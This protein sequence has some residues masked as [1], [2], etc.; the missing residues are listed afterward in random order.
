MVITDV[1]S[2]FH[3]CFNF[4]VNNHTPENACVLAKGIPFGGRSRCFPDPVALTQP[5]AAWGSL[6]TRELLLEGAAS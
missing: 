4:A 2:S 5:V 6:L 1:A 3:I